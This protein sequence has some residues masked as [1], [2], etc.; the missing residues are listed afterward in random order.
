M[1]KTNTQLKDI[2][3]S[4]K[5]TA[6]KDRV[7]INGTQALARIIMLQKNFDAKQGLDT[8]G[9]VSGYRGSPLGML[10]LTLWQQKKVLA[11]SGV[12]FQPGLNEDLAATSIWGTQQIYFFPDPKVDGVYAMWYGKEPGVDRSSDILRH[13]NMAG[14][15]KN[16]GVLVVM[17]DDHP[18]KSSTIVNQSEPLLST[19][20]IPVLYPSN[21][22]EIIDFGLL[23]W[24]LFRYSGLWVG[25]KTVNETVEQTQ[26]AAAN[27]L[28]KL[29]A[30]KD[31]Y[32]VARL[33]T[34]D[35][36]KQQL[37]EQFEPGYKL[38]FNLAPPLLSKK[39]KLT[40]LPRKSEYGGWIMSGFKVLTKLKGLRGSALDIF[41]Y[42]DE[43][44][45]ERQLISDYQADV[46]FATTKLAGE[47]N[48]EQVQLL[49]KLLNLPSEIRGF[50]HVKAKSVKTYYEQRSALLSQLV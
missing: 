1:S 46:A 25:L 36:F 41:G 43:R 48:N 7:F 30:Y 37:N 26:T 15:H 32:E 8:Q 14:S 12:V 16:G 38:K 2:S 44:K 33:Y 24:Q 40:G 6:E 34:S 22:Q 27:N 13:G 28:A 23:G 47:L 3:L 11:D 29:M 42:T 21:V 5:F 19:L 49:G 9:Y 39:D 45:S 20:G 10:D 18:G 31:E 50:G 35:K 4:D 17:G